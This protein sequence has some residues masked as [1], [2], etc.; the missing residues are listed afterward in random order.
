MDNSLFVD[1]LKDEGIDYTVNECMKNH[2]TF[3]IGGNADVYV[4]PETKE[5]IFKVTEFAEKNSIPLFVLGKGSDLLVSD[6]GIEGGVIS[7][8]KLDG[9]R[10]E[11]NKIICGAGGNLSSVCV[12]ARDNDLS[13][14]EFA[15]GIPGSVGGGLFMNAGA[16]GG[17]MKQVVSGA[18][19]IDRNGKE[20][21]FDVTDMDLSYRHSIFSE[22]NLIITEVIFE[23]Q[24]GDKKEISG[25]MQ[26]LLERRKAKQPLEYPSAGSTFKRPEGNFAGTLIEKNG[27]KGKSVG[28]AMV[29]KK[30]AGFLINYNNATAQDVLKLMDEVKSAVYKGDGIMLEPEVIFV[31]R[32]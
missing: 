2:T 31:G 29:S 27:L 13:G 18:Y 22:N 4:K 24:N 8:K 12:F 11:G 25:K 14:L 23:L 26:E 6:K 15:Y 10:R 30:H 21:Y 28:G 9:I 17:E 19:C 32:R 5:E 3:K 1:F 20:V 7:L 16:Y